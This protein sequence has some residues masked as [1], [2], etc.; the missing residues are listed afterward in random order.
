MDAQKDALSLF[1]P[2]SEIDELF[3][4]IPLPQELEDAALERPKRARSVTKPFTTE[5]DRFGPLVT[6]SQITAVQNS[7]VPVNTKKNT[8]WAVNVWTEW[9]DYR[10]KRCPTEC[11]PHLLTIQACELNDWLCRFVLEVRR[12]DGKPYPPNTLHQ[13]CCG[14]QRYLREVPQWIGR[15][16]YYGKDRAQV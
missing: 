6:Q 13:L 2:D 8:S 16:A 5:D 3:S 7:G 1:D 4:Q 14:V 11:P 15:A 12:K 10:R 9:A